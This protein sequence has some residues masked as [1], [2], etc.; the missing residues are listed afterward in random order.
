MR[1]EVLQVRGVI[2]VKGSQGAQKKERILVRTK[3]DRKARGEGGGGMEEKK[4][5]KRNQLS[6][7]K[8]IN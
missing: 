8:E 5:E 4:V 3:T 1:T 2:E 7:W 6:I